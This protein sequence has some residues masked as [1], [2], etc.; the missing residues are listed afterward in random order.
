MSMYLKKTFFLCIGSLHCEKCASLYCASFHSYRC[1]FRFRMEKASTST[2]IIYHS[3]GYFSIKSCVFSLIIHYILSVTVI[4]LNY[5]SLPSKNSTG[6]FVGSFKPGACSEQVHRNS[7]SPHSDA[8]PADAV[9]R[10]SRAYHDT[11]PNLRVM[12]APPAYK[13]SWSV[14]QTDG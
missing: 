3:W 4:K 2:L 7:I 12:R 13:C 5:V 14:R 9:T 10:P 1:S 6:R 11:Q 8:E